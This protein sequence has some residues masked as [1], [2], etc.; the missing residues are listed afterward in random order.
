MNF[1]RGRKKRDYGTMTPKLLHYCFFLRL[2]ENM[3][4]GLIAGIWISSE[5]GGF[6]NVVSA[7]QI[8]ALI[9]S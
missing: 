2:V 1:A 4:P 8:N 6:H 9:G 3:W 5:S 7:T